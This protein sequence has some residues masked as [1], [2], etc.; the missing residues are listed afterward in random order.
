MNLASRARQRE[1]MTPSKF[2]ALTP[3]QKNDIKK[4]R[5]IAPQLGESGFGCI[6]VTYKTPR[7]I[8]VGKPSR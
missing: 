3:E 4:T 6:E 8:T 2:L 5:I 1:K 7:Y